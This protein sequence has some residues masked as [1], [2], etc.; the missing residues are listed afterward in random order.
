MALTPTQKSLCNKLV[1]DYGSLV[2]PVKSSKAVLKKNMSD[3]DSYI[4]GMTFS[5]PVDL[6]GAIDGFISDVEG[7]IPG[8]DIS[9]MD[10]LGAFLQ[11]CPYLSGLAPA[12][13]VGGTTG[14]IFDDIGNLIKG[15][16]PSFPEFGASALADAI[17][18]AL[19]GLGLPGGDDLGALLGKA[20]G[21]LNCL[22]GLCASQDPSY[23]GSLTEISD[24][25]QGLYDDLNIIDSG[26]N[27]G[28]FDFDSFYTN[29]GMS[30]TQQAALNTVT[31]SIGSQKE[32]AASA[33]Q[34]SIDKV[35][36][37]TK[38]GGFF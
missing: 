17:N 10:D 27:M 37:L 31:N 20:D 12:S 21:L 6:N 16:V 35:K 14:G 19:S 29:A 30:P 3:L 34:N 33:V 28:K 36:S 25:L 24:D 1:S 18:S 2:S 8:D 4:R 7:S 38:A 15:L 32:A 5:N 13:A 23:I 9:A 11:N 22:S 26:P